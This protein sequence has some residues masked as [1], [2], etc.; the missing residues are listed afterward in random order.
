MID[1]P[2][3]LSGYSVMKEIGQGAFGRVYK[4]QSKTDI[5][6]IVA[7]KT[8][9][10]NIDSQLE[11]EVKIYKQLESQV[12]FPRVYDYRRHTKNHFAVMDFLGPTLTRLF[13]FCGGKFSLKTTI[14]IGVQ[15]L[16]RIEK[17]HEIGYVHRDIKPDNFLIGTNGNKKTVY[18]IDMG[19]AKSYVDPISKK[20]IPF[21][22]NGSFTGTYRFSSIR[23]HR[24]VEQSRRDDLES[25]GYML[26]YFLK[27]RLP[28][29]GLQGGATKAARANHIYQVKKTTPIDELCSGIPREFYLYIRYCRQLQYDEIPNYQLLIKLFMTLFDQMKYVFDYVYDWSIVAKIKDQLIRENQYAKMGI[30]KTEETHQSTRKTKVK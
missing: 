15:L 20:H 29:Q 21:R 22:T 2:E 26:I 14:M 18:M 5:S 6:R 9:P 7:I 11:Y 8:E 24:G 30:D 28:W 23:N 17:L 10:Y 1:L 27:G 3:S 19:L 4:A 25:L 13:E 12:G 16:T